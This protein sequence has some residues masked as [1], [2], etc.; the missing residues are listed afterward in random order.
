ML[1][2]KTAGNLTDQEH[3]L[4][5]SA[6][7]DLQM[8]FV[9][10]KSRPVAEE[11]DSEQEPEGDAETGKASDSEPETEESGEPE[12]KEETDETPGENT[13]KEEESRK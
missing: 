8:N 5:D 11:E 3:K 10:E 9:Q 2:S 4:L 12:D 1:R 7:S 13:D 6:I